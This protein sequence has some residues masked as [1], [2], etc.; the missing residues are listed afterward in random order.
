MTGL[1]DLSGRKALVTGASR[2]IGRAIAL[3]LAGAG[4]DVAVSARRAEDLS[5]TVA[6]ITALGRRT[7]AVAMDVRDV[8][9]CRAGVDAAA[10]ALGGLDI[11]VNNAG[12]EDVRPSLDVDEEL[13]ERIVDTNL[14]GAFFCA[15]AAARIM[16]GAGGGAIVNLCSLTSYVGIPT[17]VPYGSSKSG[18]LGMTRGLATEWAAAGIRV[19][20]IAPGYFRTAMT[21]RFYEDEAWSA[22]ML[23][24]IPQRRFGDLDDLAGVAVFLASRAS[25]Y[26]TGECIAVDGGYLAAI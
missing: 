25:A 21:D 8:A 20:A 11:L 6:A 12:T 23:A 10:A 3:A 9:A 18:L 26:V 15:Q 2:G 19:N 17:A 16:A 13:W 14:K 4:A 22:G 5:E 1:F 7:T 24:K